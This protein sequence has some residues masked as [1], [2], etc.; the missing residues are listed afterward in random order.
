M[1]IELDLRGQQASALRQEAQALS[2]R[3]SVDINEYN[4]QYDEFLVSLQK[5]L[6]TQ[7]EWRSSVNAW[8][9]DRQRHNS[10][11]NDGNS[12]KSSLEAELRLIA[13]QRQTLEADE[14]RHR[15]DIKAYVG[16]Y[17]IDEKVRKKLMSEMDEVL[18]RCDDK[19]I[20]G[21]QFELLCMDM[22]A[23]EQL[24]VER[25][26]GGE[27]GG[28]DLKATESASSGREYRWLIQC[29]YKGKD[30]VVGRTEVSQFIGDLSMAGSY[31]RACFITGGVYAN[32]ARELAETNALDLWDGIDVCRR[33]VTRHIGIHDRVTTRGHDVTFDDEFWDRLHER[34]E[35]LHAQARRQS[36]KSA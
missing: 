3:L 21:I 31:E 29:K 30:G 35:L 14:A 18:W 11:I 23:S 13:A 9:W 24:S 32:D 27:D 34:A 8:L 2:E 22:L 17:E 4:R 15:Q 20:V 1:L 12:L 33:L 19:I 25:V 26:G 36:R 7:V 16:P 5:H 6:A 10:E 28:I